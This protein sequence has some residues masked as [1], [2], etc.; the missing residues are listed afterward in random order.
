MEDSALWVDMLW[1][2]GMKYYK[3]YGNARK[4]IHRTGSI[5][6]RQYPKTIFAQFIVCAMPKGM[7][8]FVF[9]RILHKKKPVMKSGRDIYGLSRKFTVYGIAADGGVL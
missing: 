9:F 6:R 3:K 7:R 4:A 2:G 8:K 1:R 5:T